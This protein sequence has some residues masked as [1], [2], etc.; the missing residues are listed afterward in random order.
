M[1]TGEQEDG[2]QM[3][4]GPGSDAR[5]RDRDSVVVDGSRPSYR[6]FVVA[7]EH[8][9]DALGGK[10]MEVL[11]QRL[12]GRVR[13]LGVGGEDMARQGLVSQFPLED[14][15]VMGPMSILPRLPR[16][17]R[18]IFQTVDAALSAEPDAVI[19]ID[20][21]EFTHPIAK[22]IRA[23]RPDIPI[24]DYVSPTVWAW[25]PGRARKMRRYVD[26][27]LA[28]LPFEPAAHARLGGPP[29]TYVGHPLIERL[30]WLE[31]L[32]ADELG[33]RLGL[34]PEKPVLLVLPGSRSSEVSRLMEPFGETVSLLL[35][36]GHDLEV[37][38]PVVSTVRPLVE[39]AIAQ[40]PVK[41]HLV[42]GDED[43]FKSFK[44]ARAALAASGTVTLELALA[45]TPMVVAYRVDAVASL[46]RFLV[47]VPSVVLANLV[48]DET[49]FPE[50]LQEDCE[51]EKLAEA[52]E[53][54]LNDTPERKAQ[55]E[56]LGRIAGRMQIDGPSPSEAAADVVIGVLED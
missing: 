7:G 43:K 55:V 36:R 11:N 16:I 13:Y 32:D 15:A 56:A 3:Q 45:G 26:H 24:I 41:P 31:G 46:L 25:R 54:L 27:L 6:L 34:Q 17:A 5:Q 8:S 49:A 21:P 51:P 53:L 4:G 12:T 30:E 40:W 1:S 35:E 44:L 22:R 18:R 2:E 23:R 48:L 33:Q 39:E 50:Y 14:V 42:S 29:T 20:S 10:L 47:K 19:I 9:G 28:L 52:V 38:M 37:V